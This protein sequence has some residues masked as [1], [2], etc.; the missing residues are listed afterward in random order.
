MKNAHPLF[1]SHAHYHD[2]RFS[3]DTALPPCGE[4]LSSL[5]AED[6]SGIVNVGTDIETSKEALLLAERYP[7]MYAA[8]GMYPGSCP[9]SCDDAEI[10]DTIAV[11]REMLR[12]PKTAAIGEIGFDFHY[13]DV[14]RDIQAR[15]FE[16]Q[17]S[18][19]AE[20][21]YPVIVHNREA[22]GA[23]LELL[24]KF[25]SVHGVLHSYS[26]SAETAAEL[27]RMGWYISFSGVVTFKNA[28]RMA[29]VVRAVP[30][31]RTLIETDCPYLTPVPFRGRTNHSGYLSYTAARVAELHGIGAEE[32]ADITRK[33]AETLFRIEKHT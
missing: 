27:I 5:F 19:A 20:T 4:L 29:E 7:L 11:F 18:L 10:A 2:S 16:A 24:Q 31:E 14:P 13:D 28:S 30:L 22:H 8:V 23:T 25:P 15:W 32:C 33:N 1:D 26:G 3:E 12:H 9:L 21:G 6:I 17:L